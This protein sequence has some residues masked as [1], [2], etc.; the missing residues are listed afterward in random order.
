MKKIIIIVDEG[1]QISDIIATKNLE[2]ISV[3]IID[4]CTDDPEMLSDAKWVEE[5]LM[6]EMKKDPGKY[7][8]KTYTTAKEVSI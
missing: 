2:D 3:E 1:G 8:N 5:V 4:K 6:D 7:V